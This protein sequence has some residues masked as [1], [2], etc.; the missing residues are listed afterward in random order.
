M[1]LLVVRGTKYPDEFIVERALTD[2][3]S[4]D[5]TAGESGSSTSI[6]P[7][8]AHL[9]NM[10][11]IVRLMLLSA[12]ELRETYVELK[13][14]IPSPHIAAEGGGAAV[15]IAVTDDKSM[16]ETPASQRSE[17]A[18]PSIQAYERLLQTLQERLK[19]TKDPVSL[20]E[21]DVA[22]D[23]IRNLTATLFPTYCVHEKGT[24]AAIE[25]LYR[26]HEDPEL[27]EAC[28]LT[29][30][31]CR[32][33]LDPAWRESER[34][35]ERDCALWFCGKAMEGTLAKYG[36]RNE[37]SKLIVKVAPRGGPAPSGEPRMRYED[38]RVLYKEM[39][40]R[41]ELYQQLE[42]SEL[43]DRVLQQT[44]GQVMLASNPGGSDCS[45]LK[46]QTDR[47]RLI[48]KQKEE[49]EVTAL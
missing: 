34:V 40:R 3:V 21:F 46:L 17:G 16:K 2:V 31:H 36:G 20:D 25:E 29:V 6:V 1:V 24:A 26:L 18:D 14:E 12:Q 7:G 33:I 39:C 43:R 5:V 4:P 23:Q 10:R 28:R 37:R 15:S 9:V 42:E 41:R 49:R 8:I 47:L 27:D 13:G 30:Y 32:A 48:Y 19:D 38:Q 11:H 45:E 44:R 35:P 22:A